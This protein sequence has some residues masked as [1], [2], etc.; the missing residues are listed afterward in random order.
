[1]SSFMKAAQELIIDC[2]RGWLKRNSHRQK[3]SN[4]GIPKAPGWEKKR[5]RRQERRAWA[6][7]TRQVCG[8]NVLGI[9]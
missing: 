2:R 8:A 6:V 9:Q 5:A 7:A 1:M 4:A 3:R